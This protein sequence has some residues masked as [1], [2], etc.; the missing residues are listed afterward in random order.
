MK[1]MSAFF[2]ATKFK[3]KKEA[4]RVV[5]DVTTQGG[6]SSQV[7]RIRLSFPFGWFSVHL[8]FLSSDFWSSTMHIQIWFG[9][10]CSHIYYIYELM[11]TVSTQ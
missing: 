8:S 11:T 9:N 5:A 2:E 7:H 6:M 3:R 10:N 4:L 1:E